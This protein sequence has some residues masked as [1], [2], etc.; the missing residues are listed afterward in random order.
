[1]R[2]PLQS[3][4]CLRTRLEQVW[5]EFPSSC[6]AAL[7]CRHTAAHRSESRRLLTLGSV[8]ESQSMKHLL[9]GGLVLAL[10]PAA[11]CHVGACQ[12]SA[13]PFRAFNLAPST[14]AV[15]DGDIAPPQRAGLAASHRVTS[16]VVAT[17]IIFLPGKAAEYDTVRLRV[18][19]LNT[20]CDRIA[21]APYVADLVAGCILVVDSAGGLFK[22]VALPSG[23]SMQYFDEFGLGPGESVELQSVSVFRWDRQPWGGELASAT[24][25]RGKAVIRLYGTPHEPHPVF[26]A[27]SFGQCLSVDVP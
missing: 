18:R 2:Q 21:I 26:V 23:L 27:T 11:G 1:M 6:P 22:L 25:V 3:W 5:I 8:T 14:V 20:S 16:Q 4:T 7:R 17:E 9:S 10:L 24:P 12:G 13:S 15:T 19:L